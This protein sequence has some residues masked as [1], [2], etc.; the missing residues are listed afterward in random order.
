VN[1]D[2]LQ[3]AFAEID[4]QPSRKLGQSFLTDDAFSA[5]IVEQLELHAEDDVIEVGPGFGA[6]TEH[7]AGRCRGL[8]LIEKDGRL[9]NR[10]REQY[11]ADASIDVQHADAVAADVRPWFVEGGVKLIGNL[12]YSAGSEILRTFLAPPTPVNRAIIMVQKEVGERLCAQP[13]TRAFGAFSVR[14][15][16]RWKIQNLRTVGPD[17]FYP[18]PAVDS[19]ILSFEPVA[20]GS[21]PPFSGEAFD[22]LVARGFSQ[23]RKQLRKNLNIDPDDWERLCE[24]LEL[25]STVRAEEVPLLKWIALSD[26]LDDHPGKAGAQS[27]SELFDVVDEQDQVVRQEERSVV[28]AEGCLHRAVHIFVF[29]KAGELYLARRSHLKDTHP[30]RWGSSA[31]GHLD[32]GEDYADCGVRELEEELRVSPKDGMV[33]LLKLPASDET[34]QEFVELFA[35][36]PAA[37]A[38]IRTHG[39]EVAAG[40][41]FPLDLIDRWM[42]ARPDDFTPGFRSCFRAWRHGA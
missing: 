15:Q 29:N 17:L 11:A 1:S 10:L 27:D 5:W 6:L 13:G 30:G 26:H 42:A 39:S 31:A 19:S 20:P 25:A 12:P 36:R 22:S 40:R 28:H 32:A 35:C 24:K 33:S 38:K 8:T 23:R 41:H 14:M 3:E 18:R 34:D 7:L 21:L 9:A 2:Q 16:A 4:L 37:G